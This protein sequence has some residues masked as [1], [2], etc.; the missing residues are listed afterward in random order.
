MPTDGGAMAGY[1]R[2]GRV[3][4]ETTP[5]IMTMMAMT[6]AKMGLSMKKRDNMS[7]SR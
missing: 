2:T 6:H 3:T 5:A 4:T 7:D 1:C